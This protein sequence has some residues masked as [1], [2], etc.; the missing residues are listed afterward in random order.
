M[1]LSVPNVLRVRQ[2]LAVGRVV[3]IAVDVQVVGQPVDRAVDRNEKDVGALVRLFIPEVIVGQKRDDFAARMPHE[4]RWPQVARH[5]HALRAACGCR[6]QHN[7]LRGTDARVGR[8]ERLAV[9]LELHPVERHALETIRVPLLELSHRR[10][11]C[12]GWHGDI[13]KHRGPLAVRARRALRRGGGRRSRGVGGLGR[14]DRE[15][16]PIDRVAQAPIRFPSWRADR[17]SAV[18]HLARRRRSVGRH[19]EGLR[20]RP[21]V[22]LDARRRR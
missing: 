5:E 7:V 22:R 20:A 9:A 6:L 15:R 14:I 21:V 11:V 12:A 16:L 13:A 17:F 3:E 1:T 19:D 4:S 10:G 2:V 18:Q 8:R